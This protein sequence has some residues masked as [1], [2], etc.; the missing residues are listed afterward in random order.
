MYTENFTVKKNTGTK[1]SPI[2]KTSDGSET[3]YSSLLEVAE[4][5]SDANDILESLGIDF[6][7]NCDTTKPP[8][9]DDP[10]QQIVLTEAYRIVR[11]SNRQKLTDSMNQLRASIDKPLSESALLKKELADSGLS[12]SDLLAMAR[13]AKESGDLE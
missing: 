13:K 5:L 2:I 11:D 1:E 9:V 7:I 6:E 10:N 8:S 4:K 3:L 12:I